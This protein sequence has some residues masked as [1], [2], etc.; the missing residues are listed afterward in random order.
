MTTEFHV[1]G[2]PVSRLAEEFGTPLFVYDAEVLRT[3]YRSLRDRLHPAVDVFYSLKANPNVSVAGYLGSLGAGAEISSMAELLTVERA[4]FA[5]RDVIFL[6]PGKTRAELERCVAAG[7]HA[8]VCESPAELA[9]VEEIAADAG[10]DEVPVLLRVNPDFHTKGSGLAM[11]GKP[12]QFGIDAEVLRRS[13]DVVAGLRRVRVRGFHAYLGTRFLNADD[14]VHNTRRILA[15]AEELAQALDVPLETVDF[16]GGFGVAYF[17]NEKELD[18]AA[19]V[20]G[21]NEAVEPFAARHPGCRLV[22]ELGRYLTALC[23]TYVVR[24]LYVKESMG[25]TFVVADGGTNHHMAAVGVGSFVKRNFP[26][27]SLTRYHEPA[28]GSYT[29]TG[30]LCTPNDVIGKKVQLPPVEPGDLLGVE[31]SGAYGPTASPGLFLSHGFPAEVLVHQG[32]A[33][34]VRERDRAAEI[35][36]KQHLVD[37]G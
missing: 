27:R 31:R 5:A 1:Q 9:V 29:V 11:G 28:A 24:A 23:G 35:L 14:L 30:P 8:I 37:F 36:A 34:L 33:H 20:A 15:M 22:N 32:T 13:R 21:I 4:G 17:D 6:G 16:G 19:T 2:V 18:L 26:I 12:R 10:R 3:V 7:L 25:E